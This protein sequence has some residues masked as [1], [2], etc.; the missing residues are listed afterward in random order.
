MKI[1]IIS[2]VPIF[3]VIGG[4]RSR[5]LQIANT[6][7]EL[8]HELIFI[9]LPLRK[10]EI[11]DAAHVELLGKENYIKL[12]NG[13]FIGN[14]LQY[15]RADFMSKMK[16]LIQLLGIKA[17][18][19]TSLDMNY[20]PCWTHQLTQVTQ[21]VDVAMVEYVFNSRAF[22][23][24][25]DTT[26]RILDT[27]D[28]FTDRHKL[29]VNQ[30]FKIGYWFSLRAKDEN[31]GFRRADTIVAIQEEEAAH[32]KRQLALENG[33][34]C[35]EVISVSHILNLNKSFTDYSVGMCAVFV[36]SDNPSNKKSIIYFI[37][38]I[39]PLILH[40]IP[41][42]NLKLVGTICN[43]VSDLPGIIKLGRVDDLKEA[44]SNTPLSLNPMRVGTGIN[45]KLLDAM[46]IGVP[47][48]STK[49]GTRGLPENYRNGV[50]TV[51]DDDPEAFAAAVVHLAQNEGVRRQMGQAAFQD[52]QR[53]NIEQI[54]RLSRCLLSKK[55]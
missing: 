41:E 16:N 44:F 1:A 5:I 49:T 52:A 13:G 24:F 29:Y 36:G 12:S 3:P 14:L 19:Y 10:Y 34:N 17:F 23:A 30:G 48:I 9:Y 54:T 15:L 27:H 38:E 51:E 2:G 11:D 40:K 47:T 32:F 25:P 39:L 22:E 33:F 37:D 26:L 43:C 35:P 46:A 45:I 42:F 4:N 55:N 50:I 28:A 8:G 20:N 7:K 31:R 6:I 53:W 18:Y 21:N